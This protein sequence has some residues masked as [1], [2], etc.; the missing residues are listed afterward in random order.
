MQKLLDVT[1]DIQHQI[2]GYRKNVIH[3]YQCNSSSKINSNNAVLLLIMQYNTVTIFNNR[4]AL[5]IVVHSPTEGLREACT[6]LFR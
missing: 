3:S 1:I 6:E 4:S 2:A 5:F